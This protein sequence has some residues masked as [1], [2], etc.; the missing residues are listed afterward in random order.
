MMYWYK[1]NRQDEKARREAYDK[2][3]DI[4]RL[5]GRSSDPEPKNMSFW[6]LQNVDETMVDG[7]TATEL[8]AKA[9]EIWA[10]MCKD[11]GPMGLPWKK[12]PAKQR[13]EFC[14]KLESKFPVLCLCTDHYKANTVT[15]SDYSHWYKS[16]YPETEAAPK[17]DTRKC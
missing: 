7:K 17:T 2:E 16:H 9:K 13:V 12:I 8:W 14:I 6:F 10:E 15:T 1:D 11:H 5:P 4:Q 3:N